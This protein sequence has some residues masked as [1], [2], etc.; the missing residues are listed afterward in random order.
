MHAIEV[1]E[2]GGPDVRACEE[3]PRPSLGPGP[4]REQVPFDS[5]EV[6]VGSSRALK[7]RLCQSSH[8]PPHTQ[9]TRPNTPSTPPLSWERCG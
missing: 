3:E 8:N 9:V 2:T 7:S 4:C 5:L 6:D 1:A